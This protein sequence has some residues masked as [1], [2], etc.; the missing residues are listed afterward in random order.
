[1]SEVHAID[2]NAP[3]E[4]RPDHRAIGARLE[5]FHIQDEAPGMVFWHP[6][7]FA[8]IS[9][10][11]ALVRRQLRRDGYEEVRSPQL[12]RQPIWEASGH[13]QHFRGDMF[14]FDG[15]QPAALKPVSCPA[16]IEIARRRISSYRGLPYRLAE[17]GLVHRNEASGAL[18]GLF[19]LRQFV[20][21]DGHIFAAE[22]D[23]VREVARFCASA[24]AVYRALGWPALEARLS[25]RPADRAGSEAAWDQAE[26]MLAD[27]VAAA[28]LEAPP[29]PGGGAFYGPKIELSL[30]DGAGKVWQCGTIQLD[31]VMPERF[32]LAFVDEDGQRKRPV[33]LHRALFGS[34]E[35]MIGILLEHYRGVLPA[36]LCP[37]AAYVLPVGP[38]EE[39]RAAEVVEALFAKDISARA[40]DASRPLGARIKEAE[41][42]RVPFVLVI[43][44]RERASG[45]V[46]LRS[47]E[48]QV[49]LAAEAAVERIAAAVALPI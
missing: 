27:A 49:A 36:W 4:A 35:R 26:K 16:H 42:K 17:F 2:D 33:M 24:K 21:D 48:G 1:M 19:R 34:F 18:S 13:W 15:D 40:L 44:P 43:G 9:R 46:A 41:K 39:G 23:V 31:L 25:L 22:R 32:D 38:E 8:L 12:L 37:E 3:E 6:R 29:L 30:P 20:Q 47:K 7:G 45:E 5:L 28:G 14:V 10:L 11:E